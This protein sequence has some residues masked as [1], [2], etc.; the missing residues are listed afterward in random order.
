MRPL[1]RAWYA[2]DAPVIAPEL[3]NKL[4]V[5]KID[6]D[7]VVGR[8]TE[9]EAYTQDDPAS[10]THP[11]PTAR[12]AAMFGPPGH[13]YVY[14]SYGI[15]HCLNVVTAPEG[16]GQAVLIRALQP[17]EG[18]DV[19][20]RRRGRRPDRELANGPG[21]VGQALGVDLDRYGT[22]LT[23]RSSV[24]WIG[25]D[26][27]APPVSPRVGPRIGISKAIDTPWRFRP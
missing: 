20:A 2:R 26:G 5:S 14:L 27:T 11:G 12:N 7:T 10:H 24:V 21:K 23:A 15:H 3:L 6:G 25:D 18:V 4:I 19:M 16:D 22:D 13:L 8:I 1:E 17:V 9:V